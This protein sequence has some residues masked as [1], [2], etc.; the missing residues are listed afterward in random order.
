MACNYK[1]LHSLYRARNQLKTVY[2][3]LEELPNS[4]PR[5]LIIQLFKEA[6]V[7]MDKLEEDYKNE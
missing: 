6:E 5:N 4:L 7:Y 3:A 1:H 2:A